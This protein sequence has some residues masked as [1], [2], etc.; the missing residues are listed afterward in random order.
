MLVGDKDFNEAPLPVLPSAEI[1][2]ERGELE[3]N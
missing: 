3:R 1:L 2:F